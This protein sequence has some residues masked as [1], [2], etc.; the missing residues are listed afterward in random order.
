[1]TL[2]ILRQ[3]VALVLVA[4]TAVLAAVTLVVEIARF[5]AVGVASVLAIGLSAIMAI[6]FYLFRVR[7]PGRYVTVTVLMG[8][9]GAVLVAMR[10]DP[11]QID[12]HMAFF[13][14]LAMCALLYDSRA[15]LLG[16]VLVALHHL[17]LGL[18]WSD[19]VFYG[20]GGLDR[21]ALHAVILGAE[22]AALIWMTINTNLVLSVAEDRAIEVA[23]SAET[24]Q[25]NAAEILR[26]AT[27]AR[28]HTERMNQLQKEFA[29]VV[30][31]GVDGDFSRRMLSRYD[32]EGLDHLAE[33]TN[34]LVE[35][36]NVGLSATQAVLQVMAQADVTSRVNGDFKGVFSDLQHHTNAVAEKLA[37]VVG[38]L[39]LASRSLKHATSEIHF[40]ANDLSQR[41]TNQAITIERTSSAM[42][43][44]A[45]TVQHNAERA[46][47]ASLVAASVTQTAEDG[48]QVMHQA[49]EA[50]E[51]IT[52]SSTK[53]SDVIGM[54]DHIAFQTNLLALNASVEAARAGDAGKGFAVVAV[55]VRRLAQS[56]ASASADVKRLIEQ[57][58]GDVQSGSRLVLDVA[59]SLEAM[60][61]SARSSNALMQEIARDSGEQAAAIEHIGSSVRAMDEMTQHNAALVQQINGAIE[62]SEAQASELDRIV[63]I[64]TTENEPVSASYPRR[65]AG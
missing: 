46:R 57:S 3:R 14:A 19:L 31:A 45:V 13:A 62:Q 4:L 30:E 40:S 9:V 49:T 15:I 2:E 54:I 28:R 26:G 1:M 7:S 29:A 60:L 32:D 48:G 22:S 44:L 43:E 59:D 5:G 63:G 39:K 53:I 24:A 25:A 35:R 12:M 61:A 41:T 23:Q 27:S 47:E 51:R 36:V 56:T 17:G 20:A 8:Q 34:L 58:N 65:I 33:K 38:Q 11:L 18:L 50:M 52:Q 6:S 21:V 37:E 55:E 42:A 10:G 64:F 16:T